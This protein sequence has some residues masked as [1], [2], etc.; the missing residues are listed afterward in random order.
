MAEIN[1]KPIN[2]EILEGQKLL[3]KRREAA[4]INVSG[5]YDRHPIRKNSGGILQET[6]KEIERYYGQ[7]NL[8]EKRRSLLAAAPSD[9]DRPIIRRECNTR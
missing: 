8:E 9:I 4:G 6:K 2:K 5:M 7:K 1:N 3:E